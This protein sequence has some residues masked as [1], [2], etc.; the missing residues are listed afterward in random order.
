MPEILLRYVEGAG[1]ALYRHEASQAA[2]LLAPRRD[3]YDY[4]GGF[5]WGY[6]G[7]GPVNLSHAIVGKVFEFD[8]FRKSICRKHARIL[9]HE[10]IVKLKPECEYDLPV[11]AL[12]E[13]LTQ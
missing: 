2:E 8:G 7:P 11:E 1:V 12:K 10:V 4:S 6:G 9:L 3:L 5:S 13:L